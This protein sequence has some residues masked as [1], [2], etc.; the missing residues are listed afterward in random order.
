MRLFQRLLIVLVGLW[1]L[2]EIV[3]IPLAGQAVEDEVAAR[4]NNAAQVNASVGSFPILARLALTGK[5]SHVSVVLERI[6]QHRLTYSEVRF[7]VTG[8]TLNRS[9]LIKKKVSVED[10][11]QGTVTA[12][13]DLGPLGGIVGQLLS[14]V[15]VDG[16]SLNI[17]PVSYALDSDLFP[18]SPQATVDGDRIALSCTF[19]EIPSVLRRSE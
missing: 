7:D 13:V 10:I 9:D 15:S 17:G 4:D 5:V 1:L 14:E 18:C 6:A 19:T 11:D 16:H 8:V 2:A 3:A 12:S